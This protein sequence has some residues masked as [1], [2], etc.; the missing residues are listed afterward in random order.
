MIHPND[1]NE[2]RRIST[3]TYDNDKACMNRIIQGISAMANEISQ[4]K[5]EN[6]KLK[7][8]LERLQAN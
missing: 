6:A 7:V 4:L 5:S 8:E 3:N 2:L 1:M